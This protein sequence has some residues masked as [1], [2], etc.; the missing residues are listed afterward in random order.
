MSITIHLCG[1]DSP[2]P[3]FP[4]PVLVE[5][6]VYCGECHQLHELEKCPL[7]GSW[8]AFGYGIMFGGIGSYAFCDSD[9]D[10][11]WV[12]FTPDEDE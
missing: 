5:E 9:D 4:P 8:I 11:E 3:D 7:C 12:N 2:Q 10:C 6:E 1:A